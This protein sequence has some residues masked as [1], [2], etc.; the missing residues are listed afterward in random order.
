MK[1]YLSLLLIFVL[2]ATSLPFNAFAESVE[3]DNT[4]VEDGITYYRIWEN[5]NP[6]EELFTS[7]NHN[8]RYGER[9]ECEIVQSEI[10]Y[11]T[12]TPIGQPSSGYRFPD[13]GGA[14]YIDTSGGPDISVSV[15]VSWADSVS[16]SLNAG[17]AT[18]SATSA[19]MAVNFPPSTNYHIVQLLHTYTVNRIKV[20][21]YRGTD[22]LST[23]YITNYSLK[24]IDAYLVQ[25]D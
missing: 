19:G 13:Y 11:I 10:K 1:K 2:L 7:P 4:F 6:A 17:L 18:T 14:V 3:S 9:E 23:Y 22:L 5:P 15:S 16:I 24:Y 20:Y 25:T 8:A 12:T 21:T